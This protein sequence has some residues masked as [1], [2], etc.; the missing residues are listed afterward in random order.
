M[1]NL[2]TQVKQQIKQIP[3]DMLRRF[4]EIEQRNRDRR[5]KIAAFDL[6]NTLL[7][8]DI[9]DALFIQFKIDERDAPLTIDGSRIPFSWPEYDA[10]LQ[11][12]KKEEAYTSMVAS[13]V[14]IPAAT[15][16]QTTR[17]IMESG[18]EFLEA[19]GGRAPVPVPNPVTRAFVY[20]LQSL[21][22]TIYVISAS[23]QL[24]VQYV[25]NAYF[26]IPETHVFAMR[27]KMT[28]IDGAKVLTAELEKPWTVG[29][30][31]ADSY[32]HFIGSTAPLVTAGDSTTDLPVLNLTD[33]QGLIVWVGGD[34]QKWQY[35]QEQLT[36]PDRAYWLPPL[37][38][39]R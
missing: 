23:H 11:E 37:A 9:G 2:T 32:R 6:D 20:Y 35:V 39:F 38:F 24:S 26:N 14:N 19:E 12:H 21:D 29:Q 16:T 10:L 30:G 22:Y 4:E 28:T 15:L 33:P 3:G 13:Y 36:Y 7:I 25:A 31:K 34:G 8:G 17:R 1:E 5:E 27:N 18:K